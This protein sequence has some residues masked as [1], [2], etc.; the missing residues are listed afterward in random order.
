MPAPEYPYNL[1]RRL[2]L[3]AM[4]AVLVPL[5]VC[6]LSFRI[7]LVAAIIIS[8]VLWVLIAVILKKRS[9]IAY[10]VAGAISPLIGAPLV[11][12]LA[13]TLMPGE[14]S[15]LGLADEGWNDTLGGFA[16]S[17]PWAPIFALFTFPIGILM[18]II[19]HQFMR[20]DVWL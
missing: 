4:M 5:A 15:P 10:I 1:W 19:A 20:K 14:I 6:F 9:A 2:A 17:L 3:V 7:Y 12:S 18:G 11:S 13:E 8:P 16:L